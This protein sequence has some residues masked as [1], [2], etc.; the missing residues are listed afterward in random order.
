[1]AGRLW[2]VIGLTLV[3]LAGQSLGPA[4]PPSAAASP[5]LAAAQYTEYWT[6]LDGWN[7]RGISVAGGQVYGSGQAVTGAFQARPV[8]AGGDSR[9][10]GSFVFRPGGTRSLIALG[11]STSAPGAAP[12]GSTF[13]G[14]GFDAAG[15]PVVYRGPGAGGRGLSV[16]QNTPQTGGWY[17]VTVTTDAVG[18]SM[19]MTNSDGSREW[20]TAIRR[21]QIP[22][23]LN[24]VAVWNSD[25]R[26]T[27]GSSIGALGHR[28]SAAPLTAAPAIENRAPSVVWTWGRG[29]TANHVALPADYDPTRPLPLVIYAH[30]STDTELSVL[31]RGTVRAYTA[32]LQAGFAVAS[33]SQH[34]NNWGSQAAQDDLVGLYHYVNERY[35]VGPVFLL[36][37]SMGGLSSLQV[38]AH[39]RLD[40]AAWAGIYPV[41][42]LRAMWERGWYFR[43]AIAVAHGAAVDGSDY[44]TRTSGADPMT[45]DPNLFAGL[46]MRFYAS[47]DD[48]VV[49]APDNSEALAARVAGLALEATVVPHVGGHGD[50]TAYQ[51]R[52]LIDFFLRYRTP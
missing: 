10:R 27:R 48:T 22:G 3:L 35:P 13:I 37:E 29:G 51:T 33:S 30:G 23:V 19:V 49:R 44:A 43:R 7:H 12:T 16:L 14:M 9:I 46:P 24:N 20:R 4:E 6:S 8:P 11:V 40:V 39:D 15:R 36:G 18:L 25:S 45:L 32:L 50:P 34:G 17:W 47:S 2:L 38:A 28:L 5:G 31:D 52:D 26:G 41:T 21:S 42:N 1:M